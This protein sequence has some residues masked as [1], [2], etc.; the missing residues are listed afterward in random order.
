MNCRLTHG[1]LLE[2][3]AYEPLT[4]EF[5]WKVN[6]AKN[7]KAGRRAGCVKKTGYVLVAIDKEQFLGHRLAWF[8]VHGEWPKQ[9]LDHINGDRA[10]NRLGNLRLATVAEN[11]QN[12]R[13]ASRASST[14]LLGVS[15]SQKGDGF[16]ASIRV[17]GVRKHL[18]TFPSADLAYQAYLAAKREFHPR[19]T[20]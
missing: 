10:D 13:G 14:G 11:M 5:T 20:L 19:S 7:V 1:R 4:G 16:R 15:R 18:G 2:V 8:F 3:I 6:A 9:H 12:L 17:N